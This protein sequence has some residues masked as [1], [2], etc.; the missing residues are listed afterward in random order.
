MCLWLLFCVIPLAAG[1]VLF[2]P[3]NPL[4]LKVAEIV[5]NNSVRTA[6][7]TPHF[8]VTEIDWLTLFKEIIGVY[9]ENLTKHIN[10]KCRVFGC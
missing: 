3:I 1:F 8:T 5:F 9:G 10:T 4:K 6:K 2:G 7:K